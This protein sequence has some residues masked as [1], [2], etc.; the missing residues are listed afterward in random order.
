MAAINLQMLGHERREFWWHKAPVVVKANTS[1]RWL[2]H[3][4]QKLS[5]KQWHDV[6]IT[7][8]K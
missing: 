1:S 4:Q 2:W 8:R 6:L 5:L 7:A 3:F